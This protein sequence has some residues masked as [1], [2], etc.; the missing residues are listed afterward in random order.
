MHTVIVYT[1]EFERTYKLFLIA[2]DCYSLSA[3]DVCAG[4]FWFLALYIH[5]IL[6]YINTLFNDSKHVR[7]YFFSS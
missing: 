7:Q 1:Q 3:Y 5:Y 4:L 2:S 6:H